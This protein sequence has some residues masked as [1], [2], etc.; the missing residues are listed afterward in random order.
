MSADRC[1]RC[2]RGRPGP[3]RQ[4]EVSESY[5]AFVERVAAIVAPHE[6]IGQLPD[7]LVEAI[8]RRVLVLDHVR[9]DRAAGVPWCCRCPWCRVA[10]AEIVRRA[11]ERGELEAGSAS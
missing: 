2:D 5:A 11:V 7:E 3:G 1:E 8:Q 10:I 6:L 4:G 9:L